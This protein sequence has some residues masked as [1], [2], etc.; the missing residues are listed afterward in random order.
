MTIKEIQERNLSNAICG[1]LEKHA[2][3]VNDKIKDSTL[4]NMH[5]LEAV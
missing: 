4:R 1:S 3:S 5:I 2:Y